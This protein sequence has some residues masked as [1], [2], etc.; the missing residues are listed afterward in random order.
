MT[1]PAAKSWPSRGRRARVRCVIVESGANLL[2]ET[3]ADGFDETIGVAQ[4]QGEPPLAFVQRAMAR[5]E[6]VE[7]SGKRFES[8]MLL[9]GGS[10]DRA[11]KAARRL[12]VL[13]VAAQAGAYG[14]LSELTLIA[15]GDAA[16][17]TRAEML[18]LAEEVTASPN[19][20]L[21]PVRVR[22]GAP[23]PAVRERRSGIFPAIRSQP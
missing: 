18:E 3:L 12:L 15:D 5:I 16:S 6:F 22:F 8:A 17:E 4:T 7:R 14:A 2:A 19:A 13:G 1:S 21:V 23:T 9:T 10:H 11:S 20:E